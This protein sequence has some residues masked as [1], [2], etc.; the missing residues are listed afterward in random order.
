MFANA[1]NA[2][3]RN[4]AVLQDKYIGDALVEAFD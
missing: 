3:K 2:I 1:T 4:L